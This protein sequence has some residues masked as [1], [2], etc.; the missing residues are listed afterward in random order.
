MCSCA[1]VTARWLRTDSL[2]CEAVYAVIGEA[3]DTFGRVKLAG[4][5]ALFT[6]CNFRSTEV[7][8]ELVGDA[9]RGGPQPGRDGSIAEDA[10]TPDAAVPT[11]AQRCFGQ[12]LVKQCLAALPIQSVML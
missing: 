2:E 12:G 6:A 11:D 8:G 4:A 1:Q 10:A 3:R 9:N 7:P 5:L